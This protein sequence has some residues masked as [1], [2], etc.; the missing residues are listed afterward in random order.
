M[1]LALASLIIILLLVA[2]KKYGAQL[3]I[4]IPRHMRKHTDRVVINRDRFKAL[5]NP[6]AGKK[7]VLQR[8]KKLVGGFK[9]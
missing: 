4:E 7:T 9:I 8:L 5:G 6:E 3:Y 2:V 1:N